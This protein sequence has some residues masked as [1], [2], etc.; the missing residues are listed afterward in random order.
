MLMTRLTDTVLVHQS[1]EIR[2]GKE[3]RSRCH[4]FLELAYRGH[5]LL[6]FLEVWQIGIGPLVVRIHVKVV[7]P[8]NDE[9]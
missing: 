6:S 3:V 4:P 1:N 7:S 9:S 8:E 2:L 5:K